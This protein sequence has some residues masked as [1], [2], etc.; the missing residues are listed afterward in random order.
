MQ[1]VHATEALAALAEA[2]A[3][4]AATAQAEGD[5]ASTDKWAACCHSRAEAFRHARRMAT[6]LAM[7]LTTPAQAAPAQASDND[8]LPQGT[9]LITG[10]PIARKA[11][12]ARNED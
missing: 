3:A 4:E 5:E 12:L 7:K 11:W 10:K 2:L 6:K 9:M 8:I 1:S